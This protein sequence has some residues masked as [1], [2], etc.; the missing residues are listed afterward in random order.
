ME[1]LY[2]IEGHKPNQLSRHLSS[3]IGEQ[4]GLRVLPQL[5]ER[6]RMR[7]L[8]DQR[9]EHMRDA[10][11]CILALDDETLNSKLT[12]S[13]LEWASE[14]NKPV[15]VLAPSGM[16]RDDRDDWMLQR[17][18][19]PVVQG[20]SKFLLEYLRGLRKD[21]EYNADKD[22]IIKPDFQIAIAKLSDRLAIE[23]QR[24]PNA[25]RELSPRQFEEF[26]AELMEKNGYSV[27]L[28]K[29]SRDDGVDIFAVK[30]DS[31][32]R[33]LT[34]VDCKRYREDRKIGIEIVR[35]M[36]GTLKIHD[37]SHAMIATTSSFSSVCKAFES[38]HE[39]L[40]SLKDHSDIVNWAKT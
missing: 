1:S 35:G 30:T 37:A 23:L 31:F 32:G 11:T 12:L 18:D 15:I 20:D 26:I 2:F 40:L 5:K 38:K 16:K 21:F 28:T 27:T 3:Q 9:Q 33:F 22:L 10:T 8:F 19:L 25:V 13:E 36:F 7:S 39:Y 4:D 24:N 17:Y 34:V 14:Q 6:D 29:E